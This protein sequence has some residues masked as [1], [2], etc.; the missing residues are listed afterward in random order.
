MEFTLLAQIVPGARGRP[1]QSNDPTHNAPA[2]QQ[3][4]EQDGVLIGMSP[5]IG[6]SRRNEIEENRSNDQGDSANPSEKTFRF[7]GHN[8]LLR[9]KM[10]RL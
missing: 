7:D 4:Q 10:R 5:A 3:V 2:Q 9:Q 1:H 6:H 8:G